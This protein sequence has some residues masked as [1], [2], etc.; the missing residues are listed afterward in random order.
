[1]IR[2]V[3]V[4]VCACVCVCRPRH[5]V[6]ATTGTRMCPSRLTR[7]PSTPCHHSNFVLKFGTTPAARWQPSHTQHSSSRARRVKANTAKGCS[8]VRVVLL[9][10]GTVKGVWVV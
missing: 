6:L 7:A 8:R 1:M 10:W 3:C 9:G 4:C 2:Y 5:F